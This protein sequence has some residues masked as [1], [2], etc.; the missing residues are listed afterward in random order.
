MKTGK[1]LH[2]NMDNFTLF[3]EHGV[4]RLEEA[5][6]SGQPLDSKELSILEDYLWELDLLDELYA[7]TVEPRWGK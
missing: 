1:E 3:N 7:E 5:I 4:I 2:N 6:V